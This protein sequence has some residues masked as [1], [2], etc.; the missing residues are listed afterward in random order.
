[1]DIYIVEK[2]DT[3]E[4]IGRK[5]NI[6]VIEIVKANNLKA[7]YTL[8][9]GESLTIPTGLYNIFNY[10][11]VKKGDNLY[12]I[13]KNNNISLDILLGVNGLDKDEY[14]YEG[15]TILIPKQDVKLYITKTGDTIETVSEFFKAPSADVI[16]SN[17]SIYLLPGQ[18]IIYRKS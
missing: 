2:G 12:E 4:S 3:V 1:M 7:P 5:Y 10:Y 18:L 11:V 15:Q 6:P 14:I 13:A 8:R 17:N 9:E 16:Y